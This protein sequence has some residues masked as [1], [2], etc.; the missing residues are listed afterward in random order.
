MLEIDSQN[1]Q[2]DIS[3][4]G[5]ITLTPVNVV[6]NMLQIIWPEDQ[7][8]V[9]EDKTLTD[10]M[11]YDGGQVLDIDTEEMNVTFIAHRGWGPDGRTI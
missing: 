3:D 8:V 1:F 7:M 9:K 6:L 10:M 4:N 5:E 2:Y 11:P